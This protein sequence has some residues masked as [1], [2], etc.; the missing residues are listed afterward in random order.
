VL[1]TVIVASE[2][3]Q[4]AASVVSFGSKMSIRCSRLMSSQVTVYTPVS[5]LQSL[6]ICVWKRWNAEK[7]KPRKPLYS[8]TVLPRR[9]TPAA[10]FARISSVKLL[11]TSTRSKENTPISVRPSSGTMR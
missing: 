6:M 8:R 10:S 5:Y 11:P 2:A 3:V 9:P 4:D 1:A 7:S